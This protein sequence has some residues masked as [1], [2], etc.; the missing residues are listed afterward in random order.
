MT[1]REAIPQDIKRSVRQRCGFGCVICGSIP[2][3][4]DHIEEYSTVKEHEAKNLTLLCKK[5]H[6]EKTL[7][8]LPPEVVASANE[9]PF[10][11]RAERTGSRKLHFSDDGITATIGNNAIKFIPRGDDAEFSP[12]HINQTP[13]LS[14]TF[15]DDQVLLNFTVS[16]KENN[17]ILEIIENEVTHST[18][19]WDAEWR[20]NMLTIRERNRRILLKVRFLPPSKIEILKGNFNVGNVDIVVDEDILFVANNKAVIS[21]CSPTIS[22]NKAVGISLGPFGD[23][24]ESWKE[25]KKIIRKKKKESRKKKCITN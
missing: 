10:N 13:V 4:Y 24:N 11:L 7:G 3:D 6:G 15:S 14:F 18:V 19:L 1:E 5:H 25:I 2:Y 21:N 20:S 23:Y 8:F 9:K 22:A 12:L 16:D 17:K